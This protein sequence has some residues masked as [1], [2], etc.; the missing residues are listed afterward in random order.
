MR[1]LVAGS[2]SSSRRKEYIYAQMGDQKMRQRVQS[3]A[4]GSHDCE[5]CG[6]QNVNTQEQIEHAPSCLLTCR[7]ENE[8]DPSL[9]Q[10]PGAAVA[11]AGE[12]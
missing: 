2:C 6:L 1:H 9:I 7:I 11:P 10:Q 12:Q 8:D 4:Q 3:F 5:H